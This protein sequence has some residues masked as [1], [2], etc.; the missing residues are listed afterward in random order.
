M[1][2]TIP[3]NVLQLY[4]TIWI[5][6]PQLHAYE[7]LPSFDCQLIPPLGFRQDIAD[8]PL[9]QSNHKVAKHPLR[10]VATCQ[11]LSHLPGNVQSVQELVFIVL[12][13]RERRKR[14]A[15]LSSRKYGR[16]QRG[17]Q[18]SYPS[19]RWR[20]AWVCI[21][22]RYH[23][24]LAEILRLLHWYDHLSWCL[25]HH[26]HSCDRLWGDHHCLWRPGRYWMNSGTIVYYVSVLH[27]N[28]S[29]GK[30]V[31]YGFLSGGSEGW[32]CAVCCGWWIK[33]FTWRRNVINN[34]VTLLQGFSY[35]FNV[36]LIFLIFLFVHLLKPDFVGHDTIKHWKCSFRF[37]RSLKFNFIITTT[38]ICNMQIIKGI[39]HLSSASWSL[40]ISRY[41]MDQ[42][43]TAPSSQTA[44]GPSE[45]I[46]PTA[47]A[48]IKYHSQSPG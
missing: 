38:R 26:C 3:D 36:L 21:L 7:W 37:Q 17:S 48:A 32:W 28:F 43:E 24:L 45:S 40:S 5:L 13:R 47:S 8:T 44:L 14:L 15:D 6:K 12:L 9:R 29:Q 20:H 27:L 30:N 22:L 31:V 1:T 11:L 16:G 46:S 23:H 2:L 25:R 35:L 34:L 33:I 41:T 4:K 18:W 10:D 42:T 19:R 39:S